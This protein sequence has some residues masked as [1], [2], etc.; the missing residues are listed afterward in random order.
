VN[1]HA[2]EAVE[3]P[4]IRELLVS[5]AASVPGKA[6]AEALA[7]VA[8][9]EQLDWLLGAV[10]EAHALQLSQPGWRA[11]A[12]PDVRPALAR[13][14]AEGSALEP[15]PLG[16]IADLLRRA[17]AVAA[18]FAGAEQRAERPRLSEIAAGLF[19]DRDFPGMVDRAFE[20]SGEVRDSASPR[21]RELRREHRR[22][23]QRV[24]DQLEQMSRQ[25]RG[26]GEDSFVTLR[27]GRYV[28]SVAVTEKRRVTGIV[29]DRSATGHTIYLEPF[30]TVEANNA[31]AELEADE[32]QEVHRI[33]AE[34]T[35]WVRR[36]AGRLEETVAAL[37]R[38][39]ELD[40]RA[41]LAQ[42]LRAER[43]LL[44]AAAGTLRLVAMRHPL[45][46]LA[47]GGRTVPLDLTLE[48]SARGLV[49]SGPNMGGKTVVL[50]TVGLAV[51][52]ALSGLFVPAGAGTTVP[53]I[54]ELFVDIGDEQS[55][56]SDL[57]T[58]AARLRNMKA[59]LDAAG[60]RSLVL[61][62][63]L[64]A[65]TDPE[66]G[67]ALG[68]ALLEEIGHRGALCIVTTH[69]G[70]FKAFAAETSGY[71][72]AAVEYDAETL[73]PTYRLHV[74][75]PGRSHAFELA[76]R[77]GWPAD[78][79]ERAGAFVSEVTIRTETLLQQIDAQRQGLEG[80]EAALRTERA[81]A[82]RERERFGRL[83][84]SLR[85]RI[86]AVRVEKALEEDRRLRE[87]RGL[88]AE[89]RERLARLPETATAA[90]ITQIRQWFHERERKTA[91]LAKTTRPVPRPREAAIKTLTGDRLAAGA[92]AY[93]RSLGVEVRILSAGSDGLWVEH[94]GRRI[95]VPAGDLCEP[96]AE[97][98][99]PATAAARPVALHSD[100]QAVVQET[101]RGEIDLRGSTVEECLQ[102][103]DRY[104]DRAAL[105]RLHQ[106]RIIHGK[107][108]GILRREVQ[109]FLEEHTLVHSFR[110][111]EPGE[112]GWGVTLAFLGDEGERGAGSSAPGERE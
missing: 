41:R 73:R 87:L 66:E 30:E 97:E 77:E 90:E 112:G 100:S 108:Q 86:D 61:I 9:P 43:P 37:A 109:R 105:T 49:I 98:A 47:L 34:L 7:P 88:L 24:S 67:A 101:T 60:E 57:S 103:L 46:H 56:E 85:Q 19:I 51:L 80:L 48:G 92:R 91:S 6:R 54:D 83:M 58:Y 25:F 76:R 106:V 2:L 36:N 81:E 84:T 28:L 42:D 12:F 22:A 68:R 33:L 82:A 64:G 27:G 71:A 75:L 110:D 59:A 40:A 93:S 79:L 38:L 11:V 89:L 111:G 20:P 62:D 69:H 72:N 17:G 23:Q 31:I 65:G 14:R 107:G 52:M 16:E 55:L 74:G 18:Y 1:E 13:A 95:E 96:R 94:R 53:R 50:K 35:Q 104:L 4:R 32:R 39:D 10:G 8:D 45:L 29:H 26:S 21:L 70:A 102:Q 44:D 15:G 3:F 63:E 78:L 99:H 5:R